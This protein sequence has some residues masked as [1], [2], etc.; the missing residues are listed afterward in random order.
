MVDVNNEVMPRAKAFTASKRNE[1]KFRD[2]GASAWFL[3]QTRAVAEEL[4]NGLSRLNGA[5]D[6]ALFREVF[7]ETA[8]DENVEFCGPDMVIG[9]MVETANAC[10]EESPA[11][12]PSQYESYSAALLGD[13]FRVVYN[14]GLED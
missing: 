13:I 8:S 1:S 6:L 4:L 9:L 10:L 12:R 14:I 7:A 2:Q 3:L 5:Y 11:M